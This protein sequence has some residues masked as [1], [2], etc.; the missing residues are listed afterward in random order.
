MRA[1][2]ILE[3]DGHFMHLCHVE[4]C[5]LAVDTEEENI[6][7]GKNDFLKCK[8]PHPHSLNV[9]ELVSHSHTYLT[10]KLSIKTK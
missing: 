2:A 1:L 7:K 5:A 3:E 6:N 10:P 8:L 9:F 4:D